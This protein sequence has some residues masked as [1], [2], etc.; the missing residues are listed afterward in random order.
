MDFT[1]GTTRAIVYLDELKVFIDGLLYII[2]AVKVNTPTHSRFSFGDFEGKINNGI[3]TYT[4]SSTG[5][6]KTL[7]RDLSV[8][9][10]TSQEWD[11]YIVYTGT[12]VSINRVKNLVK[13]NDDITPVTNTRKEGISTLY[14]TNNGVLSISDNEIL[15]PSMWENIKIKKM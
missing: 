15:R 4:S 12:S 5:I 14:V 9:S 8:S 7:R 3:F 2:T 10:Q 6:S 1:N 13:L 11:E